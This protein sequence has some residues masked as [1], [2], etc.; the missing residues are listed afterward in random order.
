MPEGKSRSADVPRV[1]GYAAADV[2]GPTLLCVGG[3]HGNEPAGVLALRRLF[4]RLEVDRGALRG[5]IWGFS[6]NRRALAAGRRFISRDLN[7][8]WSSE[9]LSRLAPQSG[10]GSSTDSEEIEQCELDRE[11]Q[12]ALERAPRE[13]TFFLD[14]HTTSAPGPAYMFLGKTVAN[15]SFAGSI[16]LPIVLGLDDQLPGTLLGYLAAEGLTTVGVEAGQN[17]DP[18]SIDRAEAAIWLAMEACGVL[19]RGRRSEVAVGRRLLA[20]QSRSV[21]RIVR[22]TY[23][24]VISPADGFRMDPGF[25]SFQPV[26]KDR[27]IARDRN[28]PI[29]TPA[30]GVVLMPLYQAQGTDG[31]FLARTLRPVWLYLAALASKV[32][33]LLPAALRQ[34]RRLGG[35]LRY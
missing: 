15:L 22:V 2:S 14:L 5:A 20:A 7:R 12:R 8:L 6:G 32:K 27:P 24:H 35:A 31:F 13:Q 17:E 10:I 11:L 4:Q 30:A 16:P 21:P 9:H 1:I 33:R 26:E 19:A 25:Q 18:V 34:R 28:G 29:L 3:I 23:R